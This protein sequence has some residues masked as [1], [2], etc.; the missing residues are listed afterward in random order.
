MFADHITEIK[1][2]VLVVGGGMAGGFAAIKAREVGSN[3]VL[4][5]KGQVGKACQTAACNYYLIYEP[6]KHDMEAWLAHNH[7]KSEYTDNMDWAKVVFSESKARW[8]EFVEWGAMIYKWDKYGTVYISPAKEDDGGEPVIMPYRD[9]IVV[10]K[11]EPLNCYPFSQIRFPGRKNAEVIRSAVLKA[12]VKLVERVMITDLIKEDGRIVGAVGISADN[13]DFYVFRTKSVI[14]CAGASGLKATG[15]PTMTTTGDADAM[16]YRVGCEITGKEWNDP[17]CAR[18]DF[19]AWQWSDMDRDRFRSYRELHGKFES[20]GGGVP[21]Y[22]AEGQKIGQAINV[23]YWAMNEAAE[24]HAG[25]APIWWEVTSAAPEF[26]IMNRSPKGYPRTEQDDDAQ[27]RGRVRMVYGRGLGQSY[28]VSDGVWSDD[29]DCSTQVKGLYAAGDCLGIR[30]GYSG[31]GFSLA[32]CAVTGARAG[33]AAAE[34]AASAADWELSDEVL[35]EYEEIT[36]GPMKRKGGFGADW[37]TQNIQNVMFPYYVLLIKN[38]DRLEAALAQIEFISRHLV[39]KLQA[40]DMH[41][42]RKCH[43]VRSMVLNAEM[44]LRASLERKESRWEHY[45]EDYPYR[46][47]KNWLAWI[48]LG[49]DE[50]GDMRVTKVPIP[51]YMHPDKTQAYEKRY[52]V[53]LPEEERYDH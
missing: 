24:A 38:K 36:F 16:A 23:K 35:R 26:M 32:V 19:P 39:P 49:K 41:E 47:D 50:N 21:K 31:A 40:N 14:L 52:P 33:S 9:K 37:V 1:C 18:A 30:P 28:H 25:R 2:D 4:V 46:D 5:D 44:K 12:G 22:N 17:H 13:E 15:I 3:V 48:K 42:L 8:D 45:R 51:E 7:A 20:T 34:Y 53:V 10:N 27:K 29:L 11:E 43:E 6:E